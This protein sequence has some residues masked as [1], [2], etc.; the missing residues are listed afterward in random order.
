M[1]R[2]DMITDRILLKEYR[3]HLIV[4]SDCTCDNIPEIVDHLDSIDCPM[5][6]QQEALDNLKQCQKNAGIT[7]SNY[8]L[9]RTLIVLNRTTS[10]KDL[11]DSIAHECFHLLK[12]LQLSLFVGDEEELATLMG[13]I[14]S[15]IFD[16]I[17]H[18]IYAVNN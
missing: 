9:R 10:I 15:E 1:G 16:T 17:W 8:R 14:S 5:G 18:Q 6:Y 2:Y 12:H 4:L 13:N 11:I 7:Y 3:W